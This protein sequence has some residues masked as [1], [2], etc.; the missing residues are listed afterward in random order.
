MKALKIN[1]E[2]KKYT[3]LFLLVMAKY[4]LFGFRYFPILDDF[5]QYDGYKLYND[6]R[7]VYFGIGT[8][9]TRQAASLLD[10]AFWGVLPKG[11]SLFLITVLHYFSAVFFERA[12]KKFDI[13]LSYIFFVIF[14]LIPIGFESFYWLSAST[15]IVCGLFFAIVGF[16]FLATYIKS[17]KAKFL[18]LFWT[19]SFISC[20]FYEASLVF[21]FVTSYFLMLVFSKEIKRKWIFIIPIVNTVAMAGIYA[22][23]S[24][25]GAMGSRASAFSIE[26]LLTG[27]KITEFFVQLKEII[28]SGFFTLS[29]RAFGVGLGEM[30]CGKATYALLFFAIVAVASAF[31]FIKE[32]NTKKS[33][34]AYPAFALVFA[35]VLIIAPL[36]VN[37]LSEEMWLTYRS[38]GF[39]IVGLAL[40]CDRIFVYLKSRRLCAWV[41]FFLAVFFCV[42]SVGEH[43]LY[44]EV[45]EKD[46]ALC[47]MIYENTD[48][49]VRR[50]EKEAICVLPYEIKQDGVFYKDHI[51]SVFSS[52]WALTGAVRAVGENIKIKK[53]TPI[54][55][56]ETFSKENV[57]VIYFDENLQIKGV[58]NF[59][60]N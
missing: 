37:F 38:I 49:S 17:K 34:E 45:S 41:S 30:F 11:F 22:G 5:I 54:V 43:S 7:Y 58:E 20:G 50:G 1:N 39:S 51:K 56:G 3:I 9:A 16:Y 23:L 26:T 33:K 57:Y 48:E 60:E 6:L 4:M 42:G 32:K 15:R 24:G 10:P 2:T 25:V 55:C 19:F 40:F 46:V 28:T 27:E 47:K 52:D 21:S 8:I 12:L 18:A 29:I 59:G 53:V 44:K 31:L 14:L 13:N 36:L 35:L